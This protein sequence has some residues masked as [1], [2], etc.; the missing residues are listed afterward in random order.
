MGMGSCVFLYLLGNISSFYCKKVDVKLWSAGDGE[1]N[2][3]PSDQSHV[4]EKTF[5]TFSPMGFCTI[6]TV[7]PGLGGLD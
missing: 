1:A 7:Q 2:P 4:D 5:S 6:R 3:S